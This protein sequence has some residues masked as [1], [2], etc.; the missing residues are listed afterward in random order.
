MATKCGPCE[1]CDN[2]TT[3][4]LTILQSGTVTESFLCAFCYPLRES[5]ERVD[6]ARTGFAFYYPPV[7]I[8]NDQDG[9][10]ALLPVHGD[11]NH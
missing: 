3:G 11:A 6:N 9:D 7:E 2:A 10:G 1:L 5:L 8:N 4:L